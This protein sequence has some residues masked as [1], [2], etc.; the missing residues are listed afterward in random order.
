M[1][2]KDC[3]RYKDEWC[4]KIVDSPDEEMERECEHFVQ[5]RGSRMRKVNGT[6]SR[7]VISAATLGKAKLKNAE[8]GEEDGCYYLHVK[9]ETE[10]TESE[11]E[12]YEIE[13]PRIWF[14]IQHIIGVHFEDGLEIGTG[15]AKVDI[16]IGV[17]EAKGKP[18][19]TIKKRMKADRICGRPCSN[20][21]PTAR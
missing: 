2:C 10:S 19:I 12:I 18:P 14:P 7:T 15:D 20:G 6:G 5:R 11:E 17:M 9:Y 13:I 21:T 4:W 3:A 16:G 1:K 8:R